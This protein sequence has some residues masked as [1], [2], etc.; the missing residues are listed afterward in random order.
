MRELGLHLTQCGL[1]QRLPPY[2]WHLDPS[3]RLA[4]ID[5]DLKLRFVPLSG[6]AESNCGL[7]CTVLSCCPVLSVCLSET[8]VYRGQT[9]RWTKMKLGIQIGLGPDHT[10]LDGDPALPP[11]R[12]HSIPA[13]RLMSI[14]AKRSLLLRMFGC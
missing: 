14:L 12:G 5:M 10:V 7:S 1:G 9:V 4:T 6:G 13:F 3:S 8:L 11:K 2:K